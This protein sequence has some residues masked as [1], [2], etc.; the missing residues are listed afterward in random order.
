M[1]T[2]PKFLN[3]VLRSSL[4]GS[5]DRRQLSSSDHKLA[6]WPK[7]P[8]GPLIRN[9]KQIF[10]FQVNKNVFNTQFEGSFGDVKQSQGMKRT[11]SW[12]LVGGKERGESSGA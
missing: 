7:K 4:Y 12:A 9:I 10:R 6:L 3:A 11:N 5:Q 1:Q 8:V 2:S